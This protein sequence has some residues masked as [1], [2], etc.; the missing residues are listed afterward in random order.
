M[1]GGEKVCEEV[2]MQ[3]QFR[4]DTLREG[5]GGRGGT[6]QGYNKLYLKINAIIYVTVQ[7]YAM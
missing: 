2:T 1:G 7:K 5:G 3:P 4:L 6:L